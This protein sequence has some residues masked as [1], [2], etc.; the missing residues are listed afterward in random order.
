VTFVEKGDRQIVSEKM[1]EVPAGS[2][3]GG[4]YGRIGKLQAESQAS[5]RREEATPLVS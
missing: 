1:G 5:S 2:D 4:N 3:E